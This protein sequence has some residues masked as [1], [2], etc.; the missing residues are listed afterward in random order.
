MRGFFCGYQAV[1]Q[2]DSVADVFLTGGRELLVGK[3]RTLR[4][5]PASTLGL[6]YGFR[7]TEKVCQVDSGVNAWS[8]PV[9]VRC[10]SIASHVCYA[11]LDWLGGLD[12][13]QDSQSQSL[14]SYQLDD[15][16]AG[17]NKN[18]SKHIRLC[19]QPRFISSNLIG[20]SGGVNRCGRH[21]LWDIHGKDCEFGVFV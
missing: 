4:C 15:L 12:S 20:I 18:E 9:R 14:E 2:T 21:I 7:F 11:T 1:L 16:P 19:R 10:T 3:A 8:A 13:N 5:Q 6:R 17:R